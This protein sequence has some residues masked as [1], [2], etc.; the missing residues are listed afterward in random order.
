MKTQESKLKSNKYLYFF[1]KVFLFL[2]VVWSLDFIVG[3]ILDRYYFST[4]SRA[5]DHIILS[6]EDTKE[7]ILV[8]GSSRAIHHYKPGALEKKT[9]MSCYNVGL[10]G[11]KIYYQYGVLKSTLKRYDPKL[12]IL[13]CTND[14]FNDAD[15][16]DIYLLYPFYQTHEEMWPLIDLIIPYEKYKFKLSKI[17]PYNSFLYR[18]V[19]NNLKAKKDDGYNGY[20]PY[21]RIWKEPIAVAKIDTTLKKEKIIVFESFIKDCINKKVNLLL[22]ESPYYK[23]L[24]SEPPGSRIMKEIAAKYS[25]PYLDFAQDTTFI[26]HPD[27]FADETHLNDWGAEIFSNMIADSISTRILQ[28]R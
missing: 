21:K 2:L 1:F 18:V 4:K 23:I 13:D 3:T 27:L 19:T 25:I 15:I 20:E 22:V 7:D 5:K 16:N 9:S 24:K 28:N 8:F 11:V 26:N 12:I 17:Y 14:E 10:G 6:M